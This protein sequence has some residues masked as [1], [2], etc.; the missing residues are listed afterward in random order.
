MDSTQ[1]NALKSGMHRSWLIVIRGLLALVLL[2]DR[3][4]VMQ[5][6]TNEVP[7]SDL[8]REILA[9]SLFLSRCEQV[10]GVR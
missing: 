9:D 1:S 2:A 3:Q 6:A 5:P 7:G 8:L 10:G 4:Q